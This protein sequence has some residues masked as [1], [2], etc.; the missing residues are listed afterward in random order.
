MQVAAKEI[1]RRVQIIP[2]IIAPPVPPPKEDRPTR[3]KIRARMARPTR[4]LLEVDTAA[5]AE[6]GIVF[7]LLPTGITPKRVLVQ[8]SYCWMNRCTQN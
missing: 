6:I 3:M 5:I 4:S 1:P 2:V 8:I 7:S